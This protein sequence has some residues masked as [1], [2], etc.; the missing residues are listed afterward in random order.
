MHRLLGGLVLAA[1]LALLPRPVPGAELVMFESSLCEWCETWHEEV[2]GV[3]GKTP[4]G[5]A[6]PLRRVDID[7]PRPDALRHIRGIV[8]TPTFVLMAR[9]REVG[10]ITGYPGESHFWGLLEQLIGRSFAAAGGCPGSGQS[11][12]ERLC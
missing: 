10:R 5:A 6:A 3:Y 1:V 12:G 2:G 9:G 7:E 8:Y 4:E 11:A